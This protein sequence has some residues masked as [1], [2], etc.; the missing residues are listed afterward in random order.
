MATDTVTTQDVPATLKPYASTLLQNAFNY[1][2]PNKTPYYG[3]SSYQTATGE[4]P[5]AQINPLQKQSYTE[6]ANLGPSEYLGQ[7]ANLAG[8]AGLGSLTAGANYMGMASNPYAVGSFMSPYMQNVVD[9]QKSN[10]IRDYQRSMPNL[11]YNAAKAGGFGGT[12]SALAASEGNRNLQNQL[13]GIQTAG[14]QK[15]YE[16]AQDILNRGTQFNLQGYG[17]GITAA[18]TLGNLGQNQFTQNL[19]AIQ[20]RNAMGKDIYGME[21]NVAGQKY[22]DYQAAMNDPMTKMNFLSGILGKIP[23]GSNQ[24]V[25][26]SNTGLD[27]LTGIGSILAGLKGLV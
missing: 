16:G 24:N 26:S 12:R 27:W 17:Q 25:S 11:G 18:N 22:S 4:T 15:A 10:A 5:F 6:S 23:T 2:D 7:G 20:N 21:Q 3:L 9:S 14:T 19:Q 13:Q 8:A 1:A